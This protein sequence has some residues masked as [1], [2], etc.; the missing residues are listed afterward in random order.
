METKENLK[1]YMPHMD[2]LFENLFTEFQQQPFYTRND[3]PN[4]AGIYVFYK[5]EEPIYV[6]RA[7]K[8]RKRIQG[9]TR[10]SSGSESAN[11]A[12]NLARFELDE[13]YS[14]TKLGRKEMMKDKDFVKVFSS[15]KT[16]LYASKIR[17]IAIEND[18]IQT[19]F[20]PYLAVKLGTYPGNNSFENH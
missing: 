18:V 2:V 3:V 8:I 11:F 13:K 20:E 9:H 7:G 15:H 10:P 1:V 19:M 16:D 4:I 5:G 17:C 14:G 6:G 12:F